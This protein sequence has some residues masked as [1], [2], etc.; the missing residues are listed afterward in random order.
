MIPT[1][2]IPGLPFTLVPLSTYPPET[3]VS[4]VV[5]HPPLQASGTPYWV[6]AEF[7]GTLRDESD[8]QTGPEYDI[9]IVICFEVNNWRGE[10]D[11][12]EAH[13]VTFVTGPHSIPDKGHSSLHYG[14]YNLW[15][16]Q[17]TQKGEPEAVQGAPHE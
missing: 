17:E 8:T 12:N 4:R 2:A 3:W 5:F 6:P 13:E 11:N 10:P 1:T 14:A 16:P 9:G 15:T 7:P